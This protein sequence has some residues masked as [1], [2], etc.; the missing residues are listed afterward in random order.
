MIK[1]TPSKRPAPAFTVILS[2]LAYIVI[3]GVVAYSFLSK[4]YPLLLV[5]IPIVLILLI[6]DKA[7]SWY[8][9]AEIDVKNG[10]VVYDVTDLVDVLGKDVTKNK[11]LKCSS[12]KRRGSSLKVFGE[13]EV[14]EPFKKPKRVSS[15]VIK[16][17][18]DDVVDLLSNYVN[19]DK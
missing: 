13:I 15:I 18:T 7:F 1:L 12:Y 2:T 3:L 9:Y 4:M 17:A 14:Y 10:C 8:K 11:I 5:I 16:D 19:V 6:V